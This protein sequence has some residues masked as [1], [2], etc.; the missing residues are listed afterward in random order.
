[1]IKINLPAPTEKKIRIV[2]QWIN[3]IKKTRAQ[4]I[5]CTNKT[6]KCWME[7]YFVYKPIKTECFNCLNLRAVCKKENDKTLSINL[8]LSALKEYF[9]HYYLQR[10]CESILLLVA[11]NCRMKQVHQ[12]FWKME[13]NS[14]W[15][16]IIHNWMYMYC[17]MKLLA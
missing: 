3:E 15:Y 7:N 14:K 5:L 13:R 17:Q 16:N 6:I 1:M 12:T 2:K 8:Q 10:Y 11:W 9:I 4:H